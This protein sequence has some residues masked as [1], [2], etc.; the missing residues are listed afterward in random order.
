MAVCPKDV[1]CTRVRL[2]HLFIP[3]KPSSAVPPEAPKDRR[4]VRVYCRDLTPLA[5][6]KVSR[7]HCLLSSYFVESRMRF[8][9]VF[10]ELNDSWRFHSFHEMFDP[11]ILQCLSILC[12]YIEMCME[13]IICTDGVKCTAMLKKITPLG[14]CA[15]KTQRTI[16]VPFLLH[17]LLRSAHLSIVLTYLSTVFLS[18]LVKIPSKICQTANDS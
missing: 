16:Q 11:K 12:L 4:G 9:A 2:T 6:G 1:F 15:K 8:L 18:S 5:A 13:I 3:M 7:G 14:L 17:K 10:N